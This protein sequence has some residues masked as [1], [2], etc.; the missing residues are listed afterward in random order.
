MPNWVDNKLTIE[1][2]KESL[3]KLLSK[4]ESSK[5]ESEER[6][7]YRLSTSLYPMPN[8]ITYVFGTS[9]GEQYAIL[10]DKIVRPPSVE[11]FFDKSYDERIEF[12]D[13]TEAEKNK[14]IEEHGATNW[15]DWNVL[16]YGT[17]WGDCETVLFESEDDKLVF[18]FRSPWSHSGLLA[19]RISESFN[20]TVELKHDSIENW[21]KGMFLF[22]DGNLVKQEYEVLGDPDEVFSPV[23]EEE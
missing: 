13:L 21:E 11:E 9:G 2:E 22:V 15:Y 17:K 7:Y 6:I 14:L 5:F 10:Q 3:E 18:I 19:Q 8:D 1:A 16:N 23:V 4:L 20:A 12:V